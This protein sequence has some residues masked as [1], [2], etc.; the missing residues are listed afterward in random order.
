MFIQNLHGSCFNEPNISY[1]GINDNVRK[2]GEFTEKLFDF[3]V[4][5]KMAATER[6]ERTPLMDRLIFKSVR[7]LLGGRVKLLL[8]GGAPLSPETH[9]YIRYTKG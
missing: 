6:G 7:Q 9:N 1:Q 4:R 2:K 8:S 3:C 5:Y